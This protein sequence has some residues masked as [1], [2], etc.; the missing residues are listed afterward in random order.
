MEFG[1]FLGPNP[2]AVLSSYAVDLAF[3]GCEFG[4]YWA[5]RGWRGGAG[6]SENEGSKR[7]QAGR[8][9]VRADKAA[10]L[11]RLLDSEPC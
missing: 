5:L 4:M 10:G 6:L 3:L 7:Q 11:L 2:A 1:N 9:S 8:R